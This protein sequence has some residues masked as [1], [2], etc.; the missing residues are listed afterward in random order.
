MNFRLEHEVVY[1]ISLLG[2][3]VRVAPEV[4]GDNTNLALRILMGMLL[5]C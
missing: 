4:L 5:W 1:V 3:E 2:W